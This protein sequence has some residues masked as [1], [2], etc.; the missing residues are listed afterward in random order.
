MNNDYVAIIPVRGGSKSIPL[1]NIRPIGGRPLVYWTIDAAVGCSKIEK[2][3]VS[4][5]SEDIRKTVDEYNCVHAN[6][7]KVECI[8]RGRET[9]TDTASTES[10]L[11]EFADNYVFSNLVLIQATSPLLE[12]E[13]LD[14]AITKYE[15]GRYDSM[16]SVVRQKRF[17]WGEDKDQNAYISL[18]YDYYN[19]PRRQEFDG[20][21]VENG[22]FYI[23]SKKLLHEN[24]CRISGRIGVYEMSEES[25]YEIDEPSDWAIIEGLL[26]KK[27]KHKPAASIKLFATD[28]DGCMTDGGM[29]YSENGD[30]MKKF[31]TRDGMGFAVLRKHNIKT[32]IITSENTAIV[33]NRAKKIGADYVFQGVKNKL[34]VLKQIAEKMDITM[35]EIAYMGDDINDVACLEHSGL[36]FSVPNGMKEAKDAADQIVERRGGCGA[37]RAAV[38]IIID[39]TDNRR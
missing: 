25:Y 17:I 3:F 1:K 9:A 34:D 12:S 28:C 6:N 33:T 26:K 37:V 19:R 10:V 11:M 20:Y 15:N 23:T 21:M 14:K 39:I 24:K 7:G 18:N 36:S 16:L 32:A 27:K 31:D 22:A 38:D 29:Y 4:T 30:E 35:G 8:G 13:D 5:D 2:V